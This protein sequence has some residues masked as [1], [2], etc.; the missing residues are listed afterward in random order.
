MAV[1]APR[2]SVSL[3]IPSTQNTAPVLEFRCLFTHD[4]RRKAKRWQDGFLRFHTFNKRVMV[5]DVPRNFI[6]DMHWR[7]T[8]ELQDGDELTLENGVLVQVQDELGRVEQD[9]TGLWEKKLK[10]RVERLGGNAVRAHLASPARLPVASPVR[11]PIPVD[12]RSDPT[13]P[14]PVLPAKLRHRSLNALLGTPKGA[15]G[16]QGKAIIS[17]VS[18]F[19]QRHGSAV[20]VVDS[21][22][23]TKRQKTSNERNGQRE[24]NPSVRT[25]GNEWSTT[26]D[27]R[28]KVRQPAYDPI[29][30]ISSSASLEATPPLLDSIP[31]KPKEIHP[32]SLRP[33]LPPNL[34]TETLRLSRLPP[35]KKLLCLEAPKSRILFD[36]NRDPV[37]SREKVRGTKQKRTA[38]LGPPV[39]LDLQSLPSSDLLDFEI[40]D[41]DVLAPSRRGRE[42]QMEEHRQQPESKGE[43]QLCRD[44]NLDSD[45]DIHDDDH[46]GGLFLTPTP[47]MEEMGR[48]RSDEIRHEGQHSNEDGGSAG[49]INCEEKRD[50]THTINISPSFASSKPSAA[51]P[52]TPTP[53][54]PPPQPSPKRR[55]GLRPSPTYPD[56]HV[57]LL[58][59]PLPSEVPEEIPPQ[60]ESIATG[61]RD[62]GAENSGRPPPLPRATE[63]VEIPVGIALR[64]QQPQ[65]QAQEQ[66]IQEQAPVQSLGQLE[67]LEHAPLPRALPQALP[68]VQARVQPPP[69]PQLQPRTKPSLHLP[70]LQKPPQ[71][72]F[73]LPHFMTSKPA[74]NPE[75]QI[76]A[77]TSAA[78]QQV[79]PPLIPPA[80]AQATEPEPQQA[81]KTKTKPKPTMTTT[82]KKSDKTKSSKG[83]RSKTDL[84]PPV[85]PTQGPWTIEAFDLLGLYG[86]PSPSPSPSAS[87]SRSA[88]P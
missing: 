29:P 54:P 8:S 47:S 30:I 62:Q 17:S 16:M 63:S 33:H 26:A 48:E 40:S 64:Q 77:T 50:T 27:T 19:E 42:R 55:L 18:P 72:L 2:S 58:E 15:K 12:T 43:N 69:Q 60:P 82:A 83:K 52:A 66:S 41:D 78:F 6:A 24:T 88:S 3:S 4:L 34:P 67:R 37:Q 28:S 10:D 49:K 80:E 21:G 46:S 65:A 5:Y 20:D 84:A 56:G 31:P 70:P 38:N 35:R 61:S 36:T 13:R 23:P 73:K 87:S 85:M 53:L 45:P 81:P 7:E 76:Q 25:W 11:T 71:P 75:P 22:R 9:L 39:R 74:S 14:L 32:E 86:P 44:M 1:A 51:A 68:Q 59:P 79:E 57:T